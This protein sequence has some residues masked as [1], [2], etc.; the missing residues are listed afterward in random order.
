MA[1]M[2]LCMVLAALLVATGVSALRARVHGMGSDVTYFGCF[3]AWFRIDRMHLAL[4]ARCIGHSY[5]QSL[6]AAADLQLG[7]LVQAIQLYLLHSFYYSVLAGRYC[8][9]VYSW[10]V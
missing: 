8:I 2:K 3:R 5:L 1:G 4:K 9:R 7:P 6:L 10:A